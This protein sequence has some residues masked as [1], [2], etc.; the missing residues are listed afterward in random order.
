MGQDFDT[1]RQRLAGD[2]AQIAED[3]RARICDDARPDVCRLM[4]SARDAGIRVW[5]L[6]TPISPRLQPLMKDV[7]ARIDAGV[8][9]LL[10]EG[11]A[12]GMLRCPLV[13]SEHDFPDGVHLG[14]EA[15]SRHT[16]WLLNELAKDLP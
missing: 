13:M 16:T 9:D 3:A 11:L 8:Q 15:A 2:Y 14:S 6:Q 10:R 1:P 7:H 5:I 4:R 12:A